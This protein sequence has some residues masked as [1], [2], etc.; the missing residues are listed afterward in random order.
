MYYRR[1]EGPRDYKVL[2]ATACV[3]R[4][5]KAKNAKEYMAKK[6]V[7]DSLGKSFPLHII[8]F[9]LTP[10]TYGVRLRLGEEAL[11]LWGMD[12]QEVES[13]DNTSAPASQQPVRD[14]QVSLD[15]TNLKR[16]SCHSTLRT[17]ESQVDRSR[18]HPTSG[19][20]SRAHLT[21]GCAPNVGAKITGF[22]LIKV[23]A[24]EQKV[25]KNEN[26]EMFESFSIPEGELRTYGDSIW[27]IYPE[28]EI[29]VSSLFSAF[30]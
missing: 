29:L 25:M 10:R 11:E 27:V 16:G 14:G 17:G 1:N 28:K 24:L 18:F 13:E 6:V 22:D 20:G 15:D 4:K 21:L 3:T 2:H 26:P 7:K 9:V 30:Y 19:R 12:D 8:G 5:G 23:V